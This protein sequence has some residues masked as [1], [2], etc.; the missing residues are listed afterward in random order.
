MIANNPFSLEGKIILVAGAS[1]GIGQRTALECSKFGA[2]LILTARNKERLEQTAAALEG[3]GHHYIDADLTKQGDIEKIV[4]AAPPLD[5]VV[6]SAGIGFTKPFA[7]CTRA[8]FDEVF[9][10]NFFAPVELLRLLLKG[11][12]LKKGASIVFVSSVGGIS[13]FNVGNSIYGAS[14]GAL[15]SIM[16]QC[17]LELAQKKI[18]VNSVNPGMVKTKLIHD[19]MSITEE[20]LA[21]DEKRYPMKRYG[22]PEDVSRGIIYLLSDAASWITGHPLVID[23]GLSLV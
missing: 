6:L 8:M 7:F 20:Q 5:G 15:N 4:K 12:K 10:I 11:K 22:D 9:D 2:Q 16:K 17:A 21:E 13:E 18:R 3:I 1:S 14:K 23:G 19:G